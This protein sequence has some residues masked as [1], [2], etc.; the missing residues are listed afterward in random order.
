[1]LPAIKETYDITVNLGSS[2]IK[3]T[4]WKGKDIDT[5]TNI[6]GD[7]TEVDNLSNEQLEA[8]VTPYIENYNNQFLT[9]QELIF[10]LY[11][12]RAE[13]LGD[14][15]EFSYTCQSCEH[16]YNDKKE[17]MSNCEFT[18]GQFDVLKVGGHEF[19]L[20]PQINKEIYLKKTEGLD[21]DLQKVFIEMLLRISEFNFQ[22]TTYEGYTFDELSDYISKLNIS[23]YNNIIEEYIDKTPNFQALITSKCP[24]CEAEVEIDVD[25]VPTFF[26]EL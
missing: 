17:L 8:L 18:P 15:I 24:K 26:G 16:P 22:D 2:S 19:K 21:S 13:S 12:L 3:L 4:S 10:V 7:V 11:K 20:E 6:I 14:E 5:I 9:R 1:M 25:V 23:L